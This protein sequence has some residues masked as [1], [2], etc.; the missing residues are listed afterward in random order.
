MPTKNIIRFIALFM[1]IFSITT[2]ARTE[3]EAAASSFISMKVEGD[4]IV[5]S[6]THKSKAIHA[7]V[8]WTDGEK[9]LI[10]S[11]GVAL[12]PGATEKFKH[13]TNPQ[14]LKVAEAKFK[15]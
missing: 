4:N 10:T 13:S 8:Q 14:G 5:V 6:N 15:E 2:F 1:I 12:K 7:T 9:R 11:Q 3:D